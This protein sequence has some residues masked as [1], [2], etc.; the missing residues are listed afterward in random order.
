MKDGETDILC[1]RR[2]GPPGIIPRFQGYVGPGIHRSLSETIFKYVKYTD[3]LLISVQ[4]TIEI[5]TEKSRTKL[6]ICILEIVES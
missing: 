4:M 2:R 6:K 3:L 1:L 5:C